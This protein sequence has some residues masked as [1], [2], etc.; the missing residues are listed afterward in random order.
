MHAVQRSNQ[1]RCMRLLMAPPSCLVMPV[2][3]L[4]LRVGICSIFLQWPMSDVVGADYLVEAANSLSGA[5]CNRT[6]AKFFE[7]RETQ[8]GLDNRRPGRTNDSSSGKH[9]PWDP[10]TRARTCHR[11]DRS[12]DRSLPL[13]CCTGGHFSTRTWNEIGQ[14]DNA[15]DAIDRRRLYLQ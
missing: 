1:D 9:G 7:C 2:A 6:G 11:W 10:R 3:G 4:V 15:L 13:S 14:R 5:F 12:E 8:A